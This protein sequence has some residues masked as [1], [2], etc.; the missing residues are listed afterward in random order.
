ME[1]FPHSIPFPEVKLKDFLKQAA[2]DIVDLLTNP[3]QTFIPSLEAGDPFHNALLKIATALNRVENIPRN[4]Q[5]NKSTPS[6]D[7]SPRVENNQSTPLPVLPPRVENQ[8]SN[9]DNTLSTP[10][11]NEMPSAQNTPFIRNDDVD[12]PI[13]PTN[14]LPDTLPRVSRNETPILHHIPPDDSTP[15]SPSYS[16]MFPP[17]KPHLIPDD[18]NMDLPPEPPLYNL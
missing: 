14:N 11:T 5:N 8:N 3:T 1:F 16:T 13:T 17:N 7:S 6:T 4:L 10:I 9:E 2:I 15:T 18:D 12:V